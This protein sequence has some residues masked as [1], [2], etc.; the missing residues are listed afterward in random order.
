M[1]TKINI[2]EKNRSFNGYQLVYSHQSKSTMTEMR[3]SVYLPDSRKRLPVLYFLSGLTCTEQN[4]I[5][6]SG[7]QQH[8][9]NHQIV[10][11][12]PDTSPRG[13][14]VPDHKDNFI[15]H[16]A[17]FYLNA[18]TSKWKK[19]Y[20]MYDY[21][22]K[23]LPEII[24]NNFNVYRNKQGI[25][26]HS[27]GGHGALVCGLRNPKKFKSISALAPICSTINSNFSINA[28]TNYLGKNKSTW[29][30][31]DSTKV[32]S[33]YTK[34][35]E[36][37]IDQG[38]KDEFINEL[39]YNDLLKACKKNNQ[40]ISFRLHKNFTHNYY[41]ISSFIEDHL[42]HHLKILKK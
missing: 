30:E 20:K 1:K 29:E 23:E 39:K 33:K 32:L 25:M 31:Y 36:I 28:F 22:V 6:K 18:T 10:V 27:M 11:V 9:S 12:G 5:Q 7:I 16:G 8:A 19:N 2:V 13:K 37:L 21:I 42:V 38:L 4:F 41:F 40:K 17:S 35:S 24:N 34:S 3:F 15:G 14:D 26:G